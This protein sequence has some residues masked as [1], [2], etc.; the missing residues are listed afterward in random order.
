MYLNYLSFLYFLNIAYQKEQLY[1]YFNSKDI[2]S[3][4]DWKC[5][6]PSQGIMQTEKCQKGSDA[7]RIDY[8]CNE[9]EVIVSASIPH[10]EMQIYLDIYAFGSVDDNEPTKIIIDDSEKLQYFKQ[11]YK[12]CPF[13]KTVQCSYINRQDWNCQMGE[14]FI[15]QQPHSNNQIKIKL[16]SILTQGYDNEAYLLR[17]VQIFYNRCYKTCKTCYNQQKDSCTNCY[18][19]IIV[20]SNICDSCVKLDNQR[21]LKIPE[22]CLQECPIGYSYDEDYVCLQ[23]NRLLQIGITFSVQTSTHE[24]ELIKIN[25]QQSAISLRMLFTLYF[26]SSSINQNILIYFNQKLILNFNI[27]QIIQYIDPDTKV[28]FIYKGSNNIRIELNYKIDST[29]FIIKFKSSEANSLSEIK[30][31]ILEQ[32]LCVQFCQICKNYNQCQICDSYKKLYNGQCIDRCPESTKEVQNVCFE[33]DEKLD[34][35]EHLF[36]QI[37]V[38]EFFDISTTKERIDNLFTLQDGQSNSLNFQKGSGIYFAYIPNK[39]IFGGPFVWVNA[40]FKFH[41]KLTEQEQAIKLSFEVFLGNNQ[42]QQNS[43][44]FTINNNN[45]QTLV[46]QTNQNVLEDHSWDN[47]Y[48]TQKF[49]VT[50]LIY[51]QSDIQNELNILFHCD[52]NVEQ[53]FCGIQNFKVTSIQCGRGYIFD[54]FNYYQQQ[55]PCIP[56]CGDNLVL[57]NEECDDGNLEPFDGCYLCMF[58]C[59]QNC[60]FC[61]KGECQFK[62]NPIISEF[63]IIDVTPLQYLQNLC[64]LSCEICIFKTCIECHKGFYINS[65]TNQ[66]ETICGDSIIRGK[67]ECDDSNLD[68]FDGCSYCQLIKFNKCDNDEEYSQQKC[69]VCHLGICLQCNQGYYNEDNNCYS[70]CGDGL[71]NEYTEECDN[72]NQIG[73][74]NCKQADGYICVKL[75]LSPC[76]TCDRNCTNCQRISNDKLQCI[77]CF[78][79]YYPSNDECLLCDPYCI[80]CKDQSNLCT[81]CYR[82]DCELCELFPGLYTD[83]QLKQCISKCGDGIQIKEYEACDDGNQEN[84]DGCNSE[85][86]I[87]YSEE[88]L[89]SQKR[90]EFKGNNSYSIYLQD[91][92]L[93]VQCQSANITIDRYKLENFQ[94][95]FTK[96]NQTCV[97]QFSYSTS[98][99]KYNTIHVILI[100]SVQS[101]RILNEFDQ[102]LV[103]F[104]IEPEEQIIRSDT[105]QAQA[106]LIQIYMENFGLLILILIP[107]SIITE[108]YEYLWGILEVLSWINNFYF[109]NV[110]YPFVAEYFFLLSDWSQILDFPTFQGWNQPGCDYYFQAPLRF[111]N[112]GINPL[113]INNVQQQHFML[114]I[115]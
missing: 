54:Q 70:Y 43:L 51:Y 5:N 105:E 14:T 34:D 29:D 84:N 99:F 71:V 87:E 98:I 110:R 96:I 19:G 68:N 22:G 75:G 24:I 76:Q 28:A 44:H 66:C 15:I 49:I 36:W 58:Q 90:W 113:F 111:Q 97:F 38:R 23:N 89:N 57:D 65:I 72:Y 85:C 20:N 114:Q 64:E 80:T 48:K 88:I 1:E 115:I 95:N 63:D 13:G 93:I 25:L 83:I 33:L 7:I 26:S 6:S 4:G 106:E 67:E 31:F 9:V 62:Q 18:S 77:S 79:G 59:E 3:Y 74:V 41:I 73:C 27:N 11:P 12:N 108:T 91:I 104:S 92:D 10:F 40:K 50:Q 47:D 39:R 102:F 78:D 61:I 60:S 112:K 69:A 55:N 21:F 94:Y 86:Q 37:L 53:S 2:S 103:K 52:G 109:L 30:D 35:L 16:H 82:N 100:L 46:L 107:L 81:S 101:F 42:V 17:N 45:Q 32:E 8:K 56:I